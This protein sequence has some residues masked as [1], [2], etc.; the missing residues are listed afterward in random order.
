MRRSIQV[1][2][3]ISA[4]LGIPVTITVY[5]PSAIPLAVLTAITT[6]LVAWHLRRGGR[7]L[8]RRT[9]TGHL[10]IT[11]DSAGRPLTPRR[12]K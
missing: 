2:T 11:L 1:S 10:S 7:A 3:G 5:P 9:R 6:A 12:P 8:I 4:V